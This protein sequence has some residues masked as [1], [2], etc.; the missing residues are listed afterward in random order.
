MSNYYEN[1]NAPELTEEELMHYG[2]LGMKWG[3]RRA[4]KQLSSAT[5]KEGRAKAKASLDKHYTK[6]SKKLNKYSKKVDK[7]LAKARKKAVKSEASLLTSSKG[8]AKAAAKAAKF[9]RRAMR[10]M[11]KG[12][13][14]AKAMDKSF[15]NTSIELTKEQ[16]EIGKKFIDTMNMRIMTMR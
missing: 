4:S 8:R 13:K 6:S 14:W 12:E 2:V 7:N 16:R 10:N 11:K 1:C 3:V 15:K 5:T 9:R